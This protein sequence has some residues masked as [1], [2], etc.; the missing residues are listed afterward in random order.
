LK[1][2]SGDINGNYKSWVSQVFKDFN[3]PDLPIQAKEQASKISI[4]Q[5]QHPEAYGAAQHAPASFAQYAPPITESELK[6]Y[7]Q[8]PQIRNSSILSDVEKLEQSRKTRGIEAIDEI[9]RASGLYG[10]SEKKTQ[11]EFVDDEIPF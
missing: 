8:A 9:K 2:I 6:K 1:V 7:N 4:Q 11:G 5:Y 3:D 10:S